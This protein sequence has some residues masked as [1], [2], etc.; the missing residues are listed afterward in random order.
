M[1]SSFARL[2]ENRYKGKLDQDADD[3]INFAVDGANQLQVLI[4]DLLTYS[5]VGRWG[6]E[7]KEVSSE[8]VLER[9]LSNLK[10]VVEQR[11]AVVTKDPL[12]VMMGDA[13][14]SCKDRTPNIHVSS[15]R[16]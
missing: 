14:K 10:V 1:V 16:R 3:F 12:P 7:F 2:L 4:T 5:R 9:A 6:N 13:V 15:E 11:G 8:A